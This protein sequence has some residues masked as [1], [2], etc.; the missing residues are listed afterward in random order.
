MHFMYIFMWVL[1]LFMQVT[2]QL[3][4]MAFQRVDIISRLFLWAVA[5]EKL[6]FPSDSSFDYVNWKTSWLLD[7]K[8]M[9][10]LLL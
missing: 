10:F 3:V 8:T 2:R 5:G 1:Y 9:L 6:H 4:F 7:I